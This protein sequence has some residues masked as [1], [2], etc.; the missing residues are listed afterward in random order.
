MKNFKFKINNKQYDVEI[1]SIDDNLAKVN[2]N[3]TTYEVEVDRQ[4]KT[5]KTPTL[6]RSVAIPSTDSIPQTARTSSPATAKGGGAIKSPLP[7]IILEVCIKVGDKV[8]IG[9]KI[10]SLEAMKMENNINSDIDGTVSAI[11]VQKSDSVLEGDL[12]IEIAK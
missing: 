7:G 10:V 3:G 1:I 5:T 9:Q 4:L 11:H 2:V 6:V 8:S 12:L